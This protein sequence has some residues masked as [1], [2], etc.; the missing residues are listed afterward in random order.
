VIRGTIVPCRDMFYVDI[1]AFGVSLEATSLD[2]ALS[3]VEH[4][5]AL[6][7]GVGI[8]RAEITKHNR[9]HELDPHHLIIFSAWDD[10]A[11]LE[12]ARVGRGQR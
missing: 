9:T 6:T 1:P 12:A 2:D 7:V 11:L 3:M 10:I 4:W 5:L 8:A